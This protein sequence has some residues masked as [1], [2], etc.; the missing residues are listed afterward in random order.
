PR[1]RVRDSIPADCSWEVGM[2]ISPALAAHFAPA[3]ESRGGAIA[4][5]VILAVAVVFFLAYL[6]HRKWRRRKPGGDGS[7]G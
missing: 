7:G 6:G 1:R 2:L 4:L 5:T 3:S